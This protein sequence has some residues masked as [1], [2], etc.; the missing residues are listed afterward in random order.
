M[1][2]ISFSDAS[3]CTDYIKAEAFEGD[4]PRYRFSPE[5]YFR[6][7]LIQKIGLTVPI[8]EPGRRLVVSKQFRKAVQ[9]MREKV[10]TI[11]TSGDTR[12]SI[13][14]L[15]HST[16]DDSLSNG[17][18]FLEPVDYYLVDIPFGSSIILEL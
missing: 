1:S 4:T 5:E 14:Y 13:K 3:G 15:H 7:R 8:S 11:L 10:E 9:I 17:V 16:H 18:L 6:I 2:N 12:D